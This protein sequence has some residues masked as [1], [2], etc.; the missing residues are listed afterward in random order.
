VLTY[1]YLDVLKIDVRR[2]IPFF[3]FLFWVSCDA[4]VQHFVQLEKEMIFWY[5]SVIDLFPIKSTLVCF[6]EVFADYICLSNLDLKGLSKSSFILSILSF[7]FQHSHIRFD[8]RI[9]N[10]YNR[11]YILIY[12]NNN[13]RWRN[14]KV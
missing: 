4:S 9:I 14:D 8:K 11:E 6:D 2:V 7:V 10:S 5:H 13:E 1:T 12:S 3:E